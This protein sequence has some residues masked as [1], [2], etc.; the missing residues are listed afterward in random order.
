MNKHQESI[1]NFCI[2]A[3]IDHGKSTLADRFLELTNTVAKRDMKNQLLD[4]MDIERER[5]IT[6]KLQPVRMNYQGYQLNLIDTP[7]HVDFNYEV[8]RSLAAVEGAIL[9]VDATQ[10]I[11]AQTLA[12]LHLAQD[13]QLTIIPV[14]NKIDLPAAD[15]E[16][17]EKELMKLLNCPAQDIIAVS[18]KTGLNV[19]RILTDVIAKVPPPPEL[20]TPARALIFDS[21]F[22]D[23]RGVIVFVRLVSGRFV[24]GQKI[25]L[26]GT[27]AETEVMEV[28]C[29]K[30]TLQP[31]PSLECGEIGYIVTALKTITSA[32]VG[33][34]VSLVTENTKP[35]PGYKEIKPMVFAGLFC[36]EGNE[37]NKL[38]S[39]IEK[40]KLNDAALDYQ[41]ENSSAL[42]F[43]F[44]CGF[45]GLLHLEVVQ[46]RLRRE[47]NLELIVTIPAVGYRVTFTDGRIEILSSPLDFSD[48]TK[49]Q[50][51]EEPLL[52]VD[53]VTPQV[54]LGNVM[55]LLQERRA[56][57]INTEYLDENRAVLH[58]LLPL[59]AIL[60][61]F[62]SQ[63]KS[64]SSGYASMNYNFYGYQ[65]T[66]IVKL[67]I[68]VAEE[69]V[70]PLCA[71]V[72]RDEAQQVARQM[73]ER[74]KKIIPR[75]QF[76]VKIQ[77]AIGAKIVASEK[78]S[79][80]RKDVTAK[81][82]GGDVTRKMKLLNK[83]KKGKRKMASR[84]HV[85]IPSAAYLAVLRK[86]DD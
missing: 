82:Y 57:Y 20:D 77:A 37:F 81:L 80:L 56:D 72:Y 10:G 70:E 53:I 61:D 67:D 49:V 42:G 55:S 36:R 66:D 25:R 85:Q 41:P 59:T 28:G 73:V 3:H 31:S 71:L 9:I 6:I 64:I 8:S 16:S 44:R 17:A 15:V 7:G 83:Q 58:Y 60:S 32:R 23:Y 69:K 75:Q 33:D 4:T 65:I 24:K 52:Q 14:I 26:L 63:L 11:Q 40:L 78:L 19:E 45:L 74:L 21:K 79:A 86:S 12:N 22:D 27:G 47:F 39:A 43:G 29:F 34:T 84:G 50:K 13:L 68:L 18:A 62:F 54:Y 5:G 51:V 35:L 46:E 48:I 2:I 30:P 38:R 76:E 1:R